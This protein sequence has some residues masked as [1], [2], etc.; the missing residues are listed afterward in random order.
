MIETATSRAGRPSRSVVRAGRPRREFAG[1][2]E[3]RILDAASRVF[4]ER[5]FDGASID[6]I[7]VEARA[8]KPTIYARFPGKEA[9]FSA[10][11]QRKI[12]GESSFES[13]VAAG[14]SSEERLQA[15]GVALL[16]RALASDSIGLVRVAVAEC[17]RFP[18]FASRLGGMARERGNEA[19]AKLLG[20]CARSDEMAVLPA[21]APDRL[22][23]T[24]GRFTEVVV[25]PIVMRALFGEDPDALK[26]EIQPHVSDS[27]AFFLAACRT[28][29]AAEASSVKT[30]PACR[31]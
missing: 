15:L 1:E 9:L 25:L 3:E 8:G 20:E 2:V 21:F 26:A 4:I 24:A 30:P 17:R 13:P 22:T 11:F 31:F 18:E 6:E 23:A 12:R 7:A 14:S 29:G 27:V 16:N 19:I 10:A 5:G 28:S